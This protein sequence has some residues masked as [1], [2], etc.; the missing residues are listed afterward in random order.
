MA[1]LPKFKEKYIKGCYKV[2]LKKY[3]K[4]D[5]PITLIKIY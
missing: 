2:A 5:K 1:I 3:Y 4:K